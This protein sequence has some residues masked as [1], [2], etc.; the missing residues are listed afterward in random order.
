LEPLSAPFYFL[1]AG[2]RKYKP[3][4][5]KIGRITPLLA[6]G[7]DSALPRTTNEGGK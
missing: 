6:V 2:R 4:M 3:N 1:G 7:T 5:V